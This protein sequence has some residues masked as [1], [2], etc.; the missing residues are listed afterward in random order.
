MGECFECNLLMDGSAILENV[1]EIEGTP[2]IC[3]L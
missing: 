3:S 2:V 1:L